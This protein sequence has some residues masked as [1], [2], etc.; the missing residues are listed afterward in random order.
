V[1]IA[2][3]V[4]GSEGALSQDSAGG[5]FAAW[6]DDTVGVELAY[7]SDGGASWS[8]PRILFS[9]AGNPAAIGLLA[10]VVGA[11]GKG[12]AVTRSA[13]ASTSSASVGADL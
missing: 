6:L 11:S 8:K 1:T 4:V 13:S 2:T 10:S 5:I 12:W 9:N 7:S 3:D